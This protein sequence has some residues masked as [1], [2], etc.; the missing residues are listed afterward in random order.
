MEKLLNLLNEYEEKR[1]KKINSEWR[2]TANDNMLFK[3]RINDKGELEYRT[4]KC[5]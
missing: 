5:E 3:Y 1:I 4:Y 2:I